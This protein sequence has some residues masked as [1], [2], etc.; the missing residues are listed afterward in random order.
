MY[1]LLIKKEFFQDF[2]IANHLPAFVAIARGA[3]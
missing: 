2:F 1:N 3:L